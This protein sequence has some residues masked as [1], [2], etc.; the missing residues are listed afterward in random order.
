ML[1]LRI[2]VSLV[3]TFLVFA[4]LAAGCASDDDGGQAAAA[5]AAGAEELF[6]SGFRLDSPSF[7]QK[8]LPYVRIP[9]K[10][11]CFE[12]NLSPPLEWTEAPEATVSFALIAED[13][14]HS[15]GIWV[16]WVLYNIP[17][18][19]TVLDEGIPTTTAA[20]PDGTTQGTNDDKQP[21]Y[22]GPCAAL[23]V[24]GKVASEGSWVST[25]PPPRK[26]EFTLYALDSELGL[27]PGATKGELLSSMEGHILAAAKTM[28]KFKR[29]HIP[30]AG[31]IAQENRNAILTQTAIAG[32]SPTPTP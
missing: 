13:L 27:A 24:I 29:P 6:T 17:A 4:L 22:Q 31:R 10:N 28:G 14:D 15:T 19:V 9:R 1:R 23:P 3:G 32:P 16:H 7:Q 5:Q 25:T 21:G 30:P 18:E 11:S 8:V 12:D 26:Y 20:L 2:L